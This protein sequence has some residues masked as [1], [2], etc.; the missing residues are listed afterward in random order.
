MPDPGP[1][2]G[3]APDPPF[4]TVHAAIVESGFSGAVRVD[5]GGRTAFARAAGWADRR[6]GVPNTLDTQFA[7]AS[8][9]K[10]LTALAV[11]SLVEDGVLTLDAPVRRW[12]R[13]DLPRVADD[14]TVEHLLA[15]RS[16]IGD[17]LDEDAGHAITDHVLLVPVHRLADPQDYLAVLDGYPTVFPAGERFAY[18]NGGFV[19]LALVAE[20][21]SGTPYHELVSTR[22]TGRAGMPDTAFLRSDTLPGRAATGY[23]FGGDDLRTNVLHLPVRGVGDGGAYSTVA[24]VAG[25]WS[26]LAAGRVVGPDTVARMVRPLSRH[27]D[28]DTPSRYGLGFWLEPTGDGVL[29]EG[30]DAGVSFRSLHRPSKRLT[31]TVVSNWSDGAW[32]VA[33]A[34][35][36]AFPTA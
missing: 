9:S 2:P 32:P 29:L 15:H 10:A 27:P 20:R 17:Y 18:N 36:E 1:A 31:W 25:F 7:T 21:A 19:V 5:V 8:A 3:G 26:A 24:D 30:Y 4:D 11:M 35:R 34:L 33:R 23:L 22:V 16:G 6:L 28:P 13:D 12:L 14:V